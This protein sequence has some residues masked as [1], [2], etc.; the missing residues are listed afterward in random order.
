M[1]SD[2]VASLPPRAT[3]AL[4]F[5]R[6]KDL[7]QLKS[8]KPGFTSH[9]TQKYMDGISKDSA[10]PRWNHSNSIKGKSTNSSQ[11]PGTNNCGV[12]NNNSAQP[13]LPSLNTNVLSSP[14]KKNGTNDLIASITIEDVLA[15][16]RRPN[17]SES[18]Q[19]P[20]SLTDDHMRAAASNEGFAN[21]Q[22]PVQLKSSPTKRPHTTYHAPRKR[23]QMESLTNP[24]SPSKR[25]GEYSHDITSP[26]RV[27]NN[28][29]PVP[30][31]SVNKVHD[32][33]TIPDFPEQD[34]VINNTKSGSFDSD[35]VY[36]LSQSMSSKPKLLVDLKAFLK[37]ELQQLPKR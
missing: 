3:T 20:P 19:I 14:K 27:S 29:R 23:V 8:V 10:N 16:R 31:Q 28:Y 37:V 4:E 9:L 5:H 32:V 25:R 2:S 30:L 36:D 11:D 18:I 12:S 15:R 34:H 24:S 6:A 26:S 21:V 1:S 33:N 17:F 35:P 22:T 13:I 7:D